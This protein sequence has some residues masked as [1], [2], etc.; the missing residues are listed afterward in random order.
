M[1]VL[2]YYYLLPNG[3]QNTMIKIFSLKFNTKIFLIFQV[4]NY[5]HIILLLYIINLLFL[6]DYLGIMNQLF[7][8]IKKKT[9]ILN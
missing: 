1:S 2:R 3:L 6:N 7:N 5:C 9:I 8:F 4:F